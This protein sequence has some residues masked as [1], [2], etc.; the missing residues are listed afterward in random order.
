M[1]VGALLVFAF[2]LSYS[3]YR[4]MQL[5]AADHAEELLDPAAAVLL[6]LETL[7]AAKDEE[8]P[9]LLR[10]CF[11]RP[12]E[13]NILRPFLQAH[14]RSVDQS[15]LLDSGDCLILL[16]C[17]PENLPA[18]ARRFIPLLTAQ[19]FAEG[20]VRMCIPELD[21]PGLVAWVQNEELPR[22]QNTWTLDPAAW[23]YLKPVIPASVSV[24]PLTGVLKPDRVSRALRRLLAT[25]RRAGGEMSLVCLDVDQL[26]AYNE[27]RGRETGDQILKMVAEILMANCR[28]TDLI[29][30][31]EEDTFILGMVGQPE[32]LLQ[33][34]RRMSD[35]IKN[36]S[37][38]LENNDIRFSAGFGLASMPG[39]GRNPLVLMERAGVAMAEAKKRGRGVCVAYD[40]SMTPGHRAGQPPSKQTETF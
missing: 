14:L 11:T 12:A 5:E 13:G 9:G 4:K 1:A 35:A 30:R 18:V 21:P 26:A 20:T 2:L 10:L 36:A 34:V 27:T 37:I 40:V 17:P 19:G 23:P 33:A 31:L 32:A 39:D 7:R 25:H 3:R 38:A 15:F 8:R 22:P 6:I 24:D 28:E 29:G 16:K